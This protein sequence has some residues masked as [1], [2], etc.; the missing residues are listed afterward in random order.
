VFT[1]GARRLVQGACMYC[2]ELVANVQAC[3]DTEWGLPPWS[4]M[5]RRFSDCSEVHYYLCSGL[6]EYA[7]C[8]VL[9]AKWH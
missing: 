6:I 2:A 7:T 1:K 9:G 8:M 3:H 4:T 5:R